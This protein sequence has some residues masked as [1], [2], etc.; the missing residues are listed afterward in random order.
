[1]KEKVSQNL[2][3]ESAQAAQQEAANRVAYIEA[4]K[5]EAARLAEEEEKR[6][7][8]ELQ[9]GLM[10]LYEGSK[11][12]EEKVEEENQNSGLSGWEEIYDPT[13][14]IAV[15]TYA[16][17]HAY[18]LEFGRTPTGYVSV[19]ANTEPG[20][21][22]DFRANLYETQGF[23][24]AGTRYKP[25]TVMNNVGKGLLDG[26]WDGTA[27]GV[28]GLTSLVSNTVE[29][30]WG[31]TS[32]DDFSDH[33]Y[34]NQD[35]WA[36]VIGDTVVGMATGML[37]AGIVTLGI[38]FIA[39]SSTVV[40]PVAATVAVT[41]VVAAGIGIGLSELGVNNDAKNIAN[42]GIDWVQGLFH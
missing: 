3:D 39:A 28:A 35:Y 26:A 33:T 38:A 9:A 8:E 20:T 14:G 27:W 25:S 32:W 29:Y 18:P 5:A 21:R 10:A 36:S 41:A 15:G 19:T 16:A 23:D 12:G 30:G 24:F 40:V 37:A 22:I 42:A 2:R 17:W 34:K 11:A 4:Q 7:A 31:S 1:V 13:A 6:K